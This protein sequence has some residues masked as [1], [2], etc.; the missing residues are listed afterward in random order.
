MVAEGHI[1]RLGQ[2]MAAL[3]AERGIVQE[4]VGELYRSKPNDRYRAATY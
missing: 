2:G 1:P 3:C 4:G